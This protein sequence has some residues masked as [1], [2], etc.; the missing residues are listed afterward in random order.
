VLSG[1]KVRSLGVFYDEVARQLSFPSHFGRNLDAL[2]DVLV[3]DVEGPFELV[4]N[5][6]DLSRRAM[7]K[8]FDRVLEVLL[9]AEKE[10]EDFR[11]RLPAGERSK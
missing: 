11:V 2:W 3:S 5:D 1:R 6:A 9:E 10:R 7:G 4:W 8:D